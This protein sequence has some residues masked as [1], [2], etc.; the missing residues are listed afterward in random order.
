MKH[1]YIYHI[2]N[3]VHSDGSIGK[4]GQSVNP[5]RR[6]KAQGY[7]QYEI[8]EVH[9]DINIAS[10]REI[11]LQKQYGYKV[12]KLKYNQYDYSKNG[13]IA[14]R[15]NVESGHLASIRTKEGSSRGGKTQGKISYESGHLDAIRTKE[16]C[17]KGG[18]T[19][20]RKN[21]ESGK[22]YEI[23]QLA[24][25]AKKKPISAYRKDNGKY[26]GTYASIKDCAN[27]LSIIH[28]SISNFFSG[29]QTHVGGYIFKKEPK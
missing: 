20:G 13:K 9:T 5:K 3:F 1:Y 19:A 8:L 12:D 4:I 10:E 23:I 24:T 7:T 26:V 29:K 6:V 2:P 17:S 21:V 16:S 18:K 14:G 22:I 11:E 15:K 28:Y 25:E 27:T